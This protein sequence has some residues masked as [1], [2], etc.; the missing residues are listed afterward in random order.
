M[1]CLGCL[2]L[3]GGS[4]ERD[5]WGLRS[6]ASCTCPAPSRCFDSPCCLNVWFHTRSKN[7]Q[8]S[9]QQTDTMALFQQLKQGSIQSAT[10]TVYRYPNFSLASVPCSCVRCRTV[11]A[12]CLHDNTSV[13]GWTAGGRA[14]N[15]KAAQDVAHSNGGGDA[16]C[17][18]AA[19]E[20]TQECALNTHRNLTS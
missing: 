4:P 20:E 17:H 3:G 16:Q 18:S 12:L 13:H 5:V 15:A 11:R 2:T 1:S 8:E 9:F 14:S 6:F 19:R 10:T 7:W